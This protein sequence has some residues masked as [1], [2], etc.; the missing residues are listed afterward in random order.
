MPSI[1]G[2]WKL[3]RATARDAAGATLLSP[4][5]PKAMGRVTFAADGRMMSV[6]CDSRPDLP[7]SAS[8]DYSS[9]CGNYTFDGSRLI[10]R[11]DAA[12]DPSRIGSDQARGVR[13][14]GD[15]MILS[16][17]PRRTGEREEYRELTWER[18]AAE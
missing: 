1:V 11:V 3:V 4:Y 15:R 14:D 6:V 9:Y 7:A 12:S 2:T 10:T 16:P 8:R 5:G 13:F 18:I 17:P